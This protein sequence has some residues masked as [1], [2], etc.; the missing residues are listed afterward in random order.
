MPSVSIS[1]VIN[2]LTI[3]IYIYVNNIY[4]HTHKARK[5]DIKADR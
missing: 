5:E 3:Y 1:F 4:T 2:N